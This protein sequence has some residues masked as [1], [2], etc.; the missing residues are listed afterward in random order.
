MLVGL[1]Q[2][3]GVADPHVGPVETPVPV[4]FLAPQAQIGEPIES[5][6]NSGSSDHAPKSTKRRASLSASKRNRNSSS[7]EPWTWS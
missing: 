1:R 2:H 3:N 4:A 5:V 6:I 7:F